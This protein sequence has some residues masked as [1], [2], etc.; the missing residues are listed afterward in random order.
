MLLSR[1]SKILFHR[2]YHR[3]AITYALEKW[4]SVNDDHRKESVT[5]YT[6]FTTSTYGT[7]KKRSDEK[8]E[9]FYSEMLSFIRRIRLGRAWRAHGWLLE[10]VL[11]REIDKKR[12]R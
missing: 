4:L 2:S 8:I 6:R 9:R 11:V 10:N 1:K 7:T 12:R 3:P 5:N